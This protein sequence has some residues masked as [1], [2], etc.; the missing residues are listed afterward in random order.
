MGMLATVMNSLALSSA[1]VAAGVKARTDSYPYGTDRR[2]LQQWKA[3]EYMEAENRNHVCRNRK[4]FLL[5]IPVLL[6]VASNRSR[7]HAER[8][9]GGWHY[10][11]DPEKSDC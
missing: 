10:T 6:S 5:L 2:I 11:A 9:T 4:P 3:I 7:R 1:L 8:H